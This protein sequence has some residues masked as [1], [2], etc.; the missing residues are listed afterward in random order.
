MS[1]PIFG[2]TNG[3][4]SLCSEK[5]KQTTLINASHTLYVKQ[6]INTL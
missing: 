6:V 3:Y 4:D 2:F 5:R 1:Y